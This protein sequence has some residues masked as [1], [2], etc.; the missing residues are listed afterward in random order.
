MRRIFSKIVLRSFSSLLMLKATSNSFR[1]CVRC[2]LCH[3]KIQEFISSSICFTRSMNCSTSKT[4]SLA[5]LCSAAFIFFTTLSRESQDIFSF[6]S[7][8][9]SALANSLSHSSDFGRFFALL[10]S[11]GSYNSSPASRFS[12]STF[13]VTLTFLASVG[14]SLS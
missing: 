1:R 3:P 13:R 6:S 2:S 14:A 10:I 7:M 4:A 8:E 9:K 5:L 11:A 12:R